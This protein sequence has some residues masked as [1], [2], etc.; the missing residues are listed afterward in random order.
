[1]TLGELRSA[2]KQYATRFDA[3][4][5]SAA[6]AVRVVDDAAAIEKMAAAVKSLAAARVA[7]TERW[8]RNGDRSAAHHLARTTGVTV[9]DASEILRTANRLRD[10]PATSQAMRN[11]NLSLAQ[12]SAISDAAAA[13]PT[14]ERELV[15]RAG[16]VSLAEL[17]D[18]CARAKAGAIDLE[19]R[20]ARI[21]ARRC[22]RTYTDADGA[23]NLHA[24]NNPEVGAEIMAA[25]TP[26]RDRLFRVA[27]KECRHE[28]PEAYAADALT[29]LARGKSDPKRS[30]RQKVIVRVDLAA[31]VRGRPSDG[32]TCEIAG[33]GPAAVS[34]VREMIESKNTVLVAVATKGKDVVNV[35]HLG[36][37]PNAHQRSALEWLYPTCSVEGCSASAFIEWD[38]T[39]GWAETRRT[40]LG[41]L[42]GLCHF[43]HRLKTTEDWGLVDGTGK[44]AFVPPDD[45]RHPR[46]A[47]DPPAAA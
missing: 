2:M 10:L 31:L 1:M 13:D 33:F 34:A 21:H 44:R 40:L 27:R 45:P 32:E 37:S 11:G 12:A 30:G 28:P 36:R 46:H 29:D 18:E 5:I 6:D 38:H 43:H 4:L 24:R 3:A 7:D 8:K 17:R 35:A 42:D 14:K 39:K 20:R 41:E 19:G 9:A 23:W 16:D 22:L 25:L 15:A 26:I 47:H